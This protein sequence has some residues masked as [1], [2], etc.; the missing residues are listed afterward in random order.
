MDFSFVCVK[1]SYD[2]WILLIKDQ[3]IWKQTFLELYAGLYL[4]TQLSLFGAGNCHVII[5]LN[6]III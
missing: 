2:S 4:V 3:K 5:I 6:Y 1:T